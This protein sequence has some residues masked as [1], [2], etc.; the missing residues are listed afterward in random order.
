MYAFFGIISYFY[1]L[2]KFITGDWT[3]LLVPMT[4]WRPCVS[5]CRTYCITTWILDRR[6]DLLPSRWS[7]IVKISMSVCR[8]G[9]RYLEA[10]SLLGVGVTNP[11][12]WLSRSLDSVPLFSLL[13]F[14]LAMVLVPP[15]PPS[16]IPPGSLPSNTFCQYSL[17]FLPIA[18][19]PSVSL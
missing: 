15:Y 13:W 19:S 1:A 7:N 10:Y 17:S 6:Y 9:L 4:I 12:H 5:F 14:P 11:E 2:W 8:S 18:S 3:L 16:N